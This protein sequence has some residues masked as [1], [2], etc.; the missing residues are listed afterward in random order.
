MTVWWRVGVWWEISTVSHLC[1]FSLLYNRWKIIIVTR[2]YS[3][4]NLLRWKLR[5]I[6]VVSCPSMIIIFLHTSLF[7]NS[8]EVTA[9]PFVVALNALRQGCN[10]WRNGKAGKKTERAKK[11][12]EKQFSILTIRG[13][14][15]PTSLPLRSCSFD[16]FP[17]WANFR[18]VRTIQII[19]RWN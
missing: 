6:C 16:I 9:W 4:F 19:Q 18:P 12:T 2:T 10:E 11:L 15:K 17:N 1:M 13:F 3:T 7:L 14:Q 5:I 8:L